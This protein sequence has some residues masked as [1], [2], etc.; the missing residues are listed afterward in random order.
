MVENATDRCSEREVATV[1][2]NIGCVPV[3]TSPTHV[4]PVAAA[5]CDEVVDPQSDVE[6][7]GHNEK[8]LVV[9]PVGVLNAVIVVSVVEHRIR[10]SRISRAISPSATS[11]GSFPTSAT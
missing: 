8:A 4:Q 5:L 1:G 11:I 10:V 9:Q 6:A 2:C 3:T 7:H